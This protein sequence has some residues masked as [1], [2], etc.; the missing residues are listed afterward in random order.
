MPSTILLVTS[1][2]PILTSLRE[3]K[4]VD[5]GVHVVAAQR[6]A[7]T[8]VVVAVVILGAVGLSVLTWKPRP[9]PRA[10][11]VVSGIGGTGTSSVASPSR[12]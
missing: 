2:L 11:F 1:V 7:V 8:A 12:C 6:P 9:T 10:L 5:W 3:L 4:G